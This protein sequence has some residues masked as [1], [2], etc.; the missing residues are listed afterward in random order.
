MRSTRTSTQWYHPIA[1][2]VVIHCMKL[3]RIPH[4]Y[5]FYDTPF[6]SEW[7]QEEISELRRG[8]DY[9][10]ETIPRAYRL[11]HAR[12]RKVTTTATD[13]L[14]VTPQTMGLLSIWWSDRWHWFESADRRV[15]PLASVATDEQ[16]MVL[17]APQGEGIIHY[18]EDRLLL[19]KCGWSARA[20]NLSYNMPLLGMFRV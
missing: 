13:H 19:I 1:R 18:M 3:C 7:N 11:R 10:N 15:R 16:V 14:D 8:R 12:G 6:T 4:S 17:L 5:Q 2:A 9:W 20:Q